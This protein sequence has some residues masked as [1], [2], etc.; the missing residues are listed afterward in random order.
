MNTEIFPPDLSLLII[1]QI[2]LECVRGDRYMLSFP[3][4]FI[5]K[6]WNRLFNN[7][8]F[9][10]HLCLA[11]WTSLSLLPEDY[12]PN[13]TLTNLKPVTKSSYGDFLSEYMFGAVIKYPQ[14]QKSINGWKDLFIS[15]YNRTY[16]LRKL[17]RFNLSGQCM[18]Y[19]IEHEKSVTKQVLL[20]KKMKSLD[21]K[22]LDKHRNDIDMLFIL[23]SVEYHSIEQVVSQDD[24]MTTIQEDVI[25]SVMTLLGKRIL[26]QFRN[27][28]K[29]GHRDFEQDNDDDKLTIGSIECLDQ[30][31][32]KEIPGFWEK[33]KVELEWKGSLV[34]IQKIMRAILNVRTYFMEINRHHYLESYPLTGKMKYKSP[35]SFDSDSDLEN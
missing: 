8:S 34:Q 1:Q 31:N 33:V 32:E 28:R 24:R 21:E 4:L 16:H 14:I 18:E 10:Q 2:I 22:Y 29:Y 9:W 25:G 19:E 17:Q 6:S 7:E 27:G 20:A 12:T 26:F 30:Y 11:R 23:E 5:N 13:S 15:R 3:F 35:P